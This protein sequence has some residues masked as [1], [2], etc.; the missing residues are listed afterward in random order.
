MATLKNRSRRM[1][2]FNLP[3]E[4][5]CAGGECHCEEKQQMERV[6]D[7]ESGEIGMRQTDKLICASITFLG[8]ETKA[9]LPDEI[10][11]CPEIK[12][13]LRRDDDGLIQVED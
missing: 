11:D 7:P 5:Y 6:H 9:D 3:H 4:Q 12:V 2:V 8:G 13:A 10:L 1:Q